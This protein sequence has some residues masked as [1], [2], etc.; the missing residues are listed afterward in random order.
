[1]NKSALHCPAQ[2]CRWGG[3]KWEKVRSAAV[4]STP[5]LY[6]LPI[7]S[8]VGLALLQCC[9]AAVYRAMLYDIWGVYKQAVGAQFCLLLGEDNSSSA[10][11]T[12]RL[13]RG[14]SANKVWAVACADVNCIAWITNLA[15][16]MPLNLQVC[17]YSPPHLYLM[18]G[19]L[20]TCSP[21]AGTSERKAFCSAYVRQK[22]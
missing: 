5:S 2:L 9:C 21:S 15:T 4:L 7:A 22:R 14:P 18:L 1:M 16:L 20:S 17:F 10:E 12:C 13:N 6:V 8:A 3:I 19:S 11:L